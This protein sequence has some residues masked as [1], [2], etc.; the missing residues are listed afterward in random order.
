[1]RLDN[2]VNRLS[3][4]AI[5]AFLDKCGIYIIFPNMYSQWWAEAAGRVALTDPLLL[6]GGAEEKG[7]YSD[8]RLCYCLHLLRGP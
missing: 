4:E 6:V 1:M 7:F 3:P 2:V 8:V 5:N